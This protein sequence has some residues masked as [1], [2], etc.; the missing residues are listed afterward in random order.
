[1]NYELNK[2][3]LKS[4]AEQLNVS[5]VSIHN[6][7]KDGSLKTIDGS[8]T[9]ECL[10]DF[11]RDFLNKNKLS[12]RANKQYKDIHNHKQ[13]T[14]DIRLKII[15]ELSGDEISD[16]YEASLSESYKNKEGIYY[17]PQYIVE[18]MMR[19][20]TDVEGKT[21]LDP[22]CGSGNFIIEAIKKGFSPENVYG[23]DIDENAV[24]ITKKRIKELCGYE[25]DNIFCGDFLSQQVNKSTSQQVVTHR[26]CPM[27]IFRFSDFQILKFDYIFTNPPWGKK[28][29]KRDR[30]KYSDLFNSGNSNDTSSLFYFASLKMLKDDGMLGFLLPDAFFNITSF[31]DARKSLLNHKIKRLIDYGKPFKG[32]MTKAMAVVMLRQQVNE[33]TSQRVNISCEIYNVKKHLRS[34]GSFFDIPK[35]ILNFH[36]DERES[37]VVR[38]LFSKPYVTLKDNASWALGIITGNNNRLCQKENREG[39]VPIF[40]GKDIFKDK[41]AEP[42]LFIDA[43]L[44]GCRQVAD[45]DCYKAKEKIVYR[46]ICNNIV[47]HCD[48]EQRYILNSA[49]LFILNDDFPLSHNQVADLLNSDTMNWLFRC[50]FNTHKILRSDLELLPIWHE[51]F[52]IYKNFSEESLK[53]YLGIINN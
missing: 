46:F 38:K 27:Q 26:M 37:E 13:L 31:E 15:S 25:S 22:C 18:D 21:F 53:E 50:V 3:S 24:A 19:D 11:K 40:R 34:Q 1:M 7:I 42:T 28:I 17:T 2:I 8:L 33:S 48:T 30:D 23:F 6:W 9:Q 36:I 49:N 4:A 14:E 10:D 5:V 12:S 41:I 35:H 52:E 44:E 43:N 32:L 20:I 39:L 47:C 51:Y 16:G 45:I 29:N